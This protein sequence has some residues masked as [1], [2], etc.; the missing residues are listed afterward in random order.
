MRELP[1]LELL[2]GRVLCPDCAVEQR[3]AN[4]P[5]DVFDVVNAMAGDLLRAADDGFPLTHV[6]PSAA[7]LAA[8]GYAC[9]ACDAT[10]VQAI[11]PGGPQHR[12]RAAASRR[13][14]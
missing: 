7:R 5:A 9:D 13:G 10:G 1:R 3:E 12:D 8:A 4:R 11:E 14:A 6:E 2:G